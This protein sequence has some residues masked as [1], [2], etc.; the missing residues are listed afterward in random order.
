MNLTKHM[1]RCHILVK[2][3]CEICN[4]IPRKGYE[5]HMK[6]FHNVQVLPLYECNL[7]D[8]TFRSAIGVETH[9]LH[10]KGEKPFLCESCGSSFVSQKLY[11]DHKR[12]K[13]TNARKFP[14]KQCD[15]TFNKPFRLHDHIIA[16]HTSERPHV[17]DIC[18]NRFK[19]RSYLRIHK[20]T[21][22]EKSL[23]CRF[24]DR[25]FKLSENRHKHEVSI[26]KVVKSNSGMTRPICGSQ[27][28]GST[29]DVQPT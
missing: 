1:H 24:C 19:S 12:A 17:C 5:R 8:A 15:R 16:F 11:R 7:C 2:R 18:G 13:H 3:K 20:L 27:C 22:G 29:N 21:H 9:V 23:K 26:H 25:M 28:G 10:H 6:K 4:K 14:C